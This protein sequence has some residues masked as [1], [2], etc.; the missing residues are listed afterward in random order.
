M[1]RHLKSYGTHGICCCWCCWR[2]W[3][4]I[5]GPEIPR[6]PFPD[7]AP[8]LWKFVNE[9]DARWTGSSWFAGPDCC[10]WLALKGNMGGA[11]GNCSRPPLEND[12]P[13]V[14]M[15][16]TVPNSCC[17]VQRLFTF[18]TVVFPF[19]SLL[20]WSVDW[21]S[22]SHQKVRITEGSE[23]RTLR[24]TESPS[25]WRPKTAQKKPCTEEATKS[26]PFF[27]QLPTL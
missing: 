3:F 13:F 14:G 23:T 11:F 25:C 10:S 12:K 16:L 21:A 8:L 26:H 24:A 4:P 1:L 19:H 9:N 17:F 7:A 15:A 6:A 20:G 22:S 18:S 27:L 2:L 5:I